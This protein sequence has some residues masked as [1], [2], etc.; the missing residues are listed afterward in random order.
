M[1]CI[2]GII[3][4][5]L[6]VIFLAGFVMYENPKLIFALLTIPAL[7]DVYLAMILLSVATFVIINLAPSWYNPWWVRRNK[8]ILY[9]YLSRMKLL[10]LLIKY[11][12]ADKWKCAHTPFKWG[13]TGPS[14]NKRYC[15]RF[16]ASS[17][18]GAEFKNKSVLVP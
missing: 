10:M 13:Q 8:K 14:K 4:I 17:K 6:R 15:P 3:Q 9:K 16:Y 12:N 11:W 7:Y 5:W 1:V 2:Q 18:G